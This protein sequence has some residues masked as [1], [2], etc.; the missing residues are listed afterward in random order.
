MQSIH[1]RIIIRL[2]NL[3]F[4]LYLVECAELAGDLEPVLVA[5]CSQ[6]LDLAASKVAII[7]AIKAADGRPTMAVPEG[8][9]PE[10]MARETSLKACRKR[11]SDS[12]SSGSPWR[13]VQKGRKLG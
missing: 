8:R 11:S 5:S 13:A 12:D 9:P 6:E 3:K 7:L 1:S 10:D 2:Q 4:N